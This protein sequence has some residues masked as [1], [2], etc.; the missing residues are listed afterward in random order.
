MLVLSR[1]QDEVIRIGDDIEV[2]VV[3]I[4][5]DKVRLGI[6]APSGTSVHREEVYQRILDEM[7][8]EHPA[9]ES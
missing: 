4:R 1:K 6:T 8:T 2:R 5:G 7:N 3:Q 9:S